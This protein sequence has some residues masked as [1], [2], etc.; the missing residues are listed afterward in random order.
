MRILILED[1]GSRVRFFIERFGKHD[2]SITENA[3]RAIKYLEDYVFDYIFL[4]N[5]LGSGNGE[6]IDVA[7]YLQYNPDNLNN[8]AI[9][10]VHSWN[11]PAVRTIQDKLPYAFAAPF[12]TETFF[13]LRL[14]I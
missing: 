14:D 2:L 9:I 5:D 11:V 6:G 8:K 4:D 1:D 10:V 3:S 12:N 13:N 7:D